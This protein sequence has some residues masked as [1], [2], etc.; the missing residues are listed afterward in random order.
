M[1]RGLIRVAVMLLAIAMVLPIVAA[2]GDGNN[3][4][5][6]AVTITGWFYP[7]YNVAGMSPGEF[8]QSL[9]DEF[10]SLPGNEHI[11]INFEMIAWD[12]GPE[13]VNVAIAT[14]DAPDFVFDFPGRIVGYGLAGALVPLDDMIS[15]EVKAD[16]PESVW[17]HCRGNGQ[18]W[19]YPTGITYIGMAVNRKI[20]REA[21]LDH[22]VPT[23]ATRTWTHAQ[24]EEVLQGLVDA[25]LEDPFI[26]PFSIAALNEQGDATTR[27]IVQNFGTDFIN[28]QHTEIVLNSPQGIAGYQWLLD[29]YERGFIV[30]NPETV[31]A[32]HILDFFMQSQVAFAM[33]W[34]GGN[35]NALN[36]RI[37]AGEAD[38]EFDC[39]FMTL[40]TPTGTNP[41]VESQVVGFGI[42]DN[43]DAARAQAAF[44][45]VQ[46]MAEKAE[47]VV[48]QAIF[49][50]RNSMPITLLAEMD[51]RYV[52]PE[53]QFLSSLIPYLGDTGYTMRNYALVRAEFF[54]QMQAIF[55]GM[56]TV[57]QAL[58]DFAEAANRHLQS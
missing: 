55:T 48:A 12:T 41:K 40:P 34:A 50:V 10:T 3:A 26:A 24:F 31:S 46:F 28:P 49:P 30:R 52:N 37:A 29:M 11:T 15:A 13:Q 35:L 36:N 20:L 53:L 1:K 47:C 38:P 7:R 14:G 2:C 54:P 17:S 27:M 57:E 42:F 21:G 16:I 9:I 44:D 6:E 4:G 5:S 56:K 39:W 51:D 43:N 33:G 32:T 58:N 19:M 22:L 45:F 18:I 8:E 23:N 25:N